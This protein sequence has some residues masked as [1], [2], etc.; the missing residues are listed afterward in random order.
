M[1]NI[2]NNLDDNIKHIKNL[3]H[4]TSDL[5]VRKLKYGRH[6]S[7]YA[8]IIYIDGIIDSEIIQEF[9]I[10]PL[11]DFTE[12]AKKNITIDLVSEVIESANFRMV[13]Q[14]QEVTNEIVNGNTVVLLEG[15]NKAITVD[16]PMWNERSIEEALGERVPQGPIIGLTEKLRT[17]INILRSM[18]KSPDLCIENREVGAISKTQ[19]S[20]VY[21]NGIVDKGI[22]KKVQSRLSNL[23]IKYLL[24]AR[25]IDEVIEGKKSIFTLNKRTERPDVLASS[26]Y[27]GKVGIIVDGTPFAIITPSLFI[28]SF[29]T[30]DD[31]FLK[32]GRFTSRFMRFGGFFLS[33]YLPGIYVALEKFHQDNY[34][35]KVVKSLFSDGELLPVFWEMLLLLFILKI[36]MDATF[37]I[38]KSSIILISLVATI[39]IGQTAVTAKLLHPASL[40]TIGITF[41]ASFLIVYRG[42]AE[43]MGTLRFLFVIAAALLGFNG[44]IVGT[45]ILILYMTNLKSAGVPYLSPIIPLRFKELK[46][47]LYRG[48]LKSL[49]NSKHSYPD[50]N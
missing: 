8:A 1:I 29:Q 33:V 41:L 9:V 11:L 12:P 17:N 28:E 4:Q 20:V 2:E 6:R 3:F 46:D 5:V 26:L 27:E 49:I 50:N 30:P 19:I 39:I 47:T 15:H 44:L 38:P 24:E 21:M 14:F 43:A 18:I 23:S 42:L 35:E 16:T 7:K 22:L 31:Y 32:A 25:I 48:D 10:K 45:T 13:T 36:L 40:I 34:S 37:R